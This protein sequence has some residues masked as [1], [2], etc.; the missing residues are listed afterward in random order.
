VLAAM[1]AGPIR[2]DPDRVDV[3]FGSVTVCRDGV[4]AAFDPAKAAAELRNPDVD[5][6][7]DLGLGQS[8]ATVLT[9][10]LTHEY[11]TIN[12]EYTT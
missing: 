7:V 4:I 5:L 9:C 6:V 10:D 1:G 8:E 11:V 2:F 3:A 12:A